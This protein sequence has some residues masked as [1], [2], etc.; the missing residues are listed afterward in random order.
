[1]MNRAQVNILI[2]FQDALIKSLTPAQYDTWM[3]YTETCT[4][5]DIVDGITDLIS[6]IDTNELPA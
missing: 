1:M 4:D 5:G 6:F 3:G 2:D